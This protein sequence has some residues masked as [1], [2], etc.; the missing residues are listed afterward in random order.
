MS[1]RERE[2]AFFLK[3]REEEA[4]DDEEKTFSLD[5]I[6]SKTTSFS[7]SFPPS[8]LSFSDSQPR[9]RGVK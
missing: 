2:G 4:V 8:K 5:R 1:E 7:L 6:S 9:R 3:K